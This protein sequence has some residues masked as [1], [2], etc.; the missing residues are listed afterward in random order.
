MT[1]LIRWFRGENFLSDKWSRRLDI[2]MMAVAIFAVVQVIGLYVLF[3]E[4]ATRHL[5]N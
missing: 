2:F 4:V 5:E 1:R 3:V